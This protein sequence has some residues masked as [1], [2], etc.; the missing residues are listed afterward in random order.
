MLQP[1]CCFRRCHFITVV[2]MV[3]VGWAAFVGIA[4]GADGVKQKGTDCSVPFV[5]H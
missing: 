5:M 2:L 4:V 1:L 3:A